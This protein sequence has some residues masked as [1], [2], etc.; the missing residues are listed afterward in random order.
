[1]ERQRLFCKGQSALLAR[2]HSLRAA[3]EKRVRRMR[4]IGA[5]S[6]KTAGR[7][8]GLLVATSAA[9][10]LVLVAHSSSAAQLSRVVRQADSTNETTTTAPSAAPESP[11]TS[12]SPS[13]TPGVLAS[14]TTTQKPA[15]GSKYAPVNF[16]LV[17]Q[18]FKETLDEKEVASKW[19]QMDKT[20]NEGVRSILKIVFPH[21][22][23]MSSDAKVSGNCSGAILKW[24][25]NLR[26]MRE[27]AVKMLDAIGKPSAGILEG[28]LTMFGNYKQCLAIRAPDEDEIEINDDQF[29]EYFRGQYCVLQIRPPLPQKRPFYSLNSTI[30]TLLRPSYK[31]YEK[32]VYDSLAELAM[33]FNY[34]SIRADLCVPSLCSRD[35][36]QRVADFLAKKVNMRALIQRCDI[37]PF[38][39]DHEGAGSDHHSTIDQSHLLWSMI[40]IILFLLVLVSTL[41]SL[42]IK[43]GRKSS[44]SKLAKIKNKSIFTSMSVYRSLSHIKNVHMDRINDSKPVFLYSLRLIIILWIFLISLTSQLDFQYLRELLTLRNM[45]MQWPMQLIV[46]S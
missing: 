37:E 12:D 16:T 19:R 44:N 13:P 4:E 32:N 20:L 41:T 21:I 7:K 34:V 27:W 18:L 11:A 31:Y 36:I 14:T 15:G 5:P 9:L 35:D 6:L 25:L 2:P 3:G 42:L 46:N 45:I 17:E 39:T 38:E 30:N 22:V 33:A 29:R 40:F 1:M 28:S 43:V 26:N 10:V 23:A 24:I 8:L